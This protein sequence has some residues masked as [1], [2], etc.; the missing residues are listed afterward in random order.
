[1]RGVL[2]A[3]LINRA[4]Q[5]HHHPQSIFSRVSY[6]YVSFIVGSSSRKCS[7]A[8]NWRKPNF[9]DCTSSE[10]LKLANM[11]YSYLSHLRR[12]KKKQTNKQTNKQRKRN[13]ISGY[14]TISHFLSG[15]NRTFKV[16]KKKLKSDEICG[17]G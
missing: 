8:G 17:G 11:V 5:Q 14:E 16:K 4:I 6:L 2:S 12:K 10:F 7:K 9:T 1:M 3:Y 13:K 15:N